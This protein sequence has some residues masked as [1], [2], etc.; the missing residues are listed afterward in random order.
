MIKQKFLTQNGIDRLS[1][2]C[3]FTGAKASVITEKTG[4]SRVGR[5]VKFKREADQL[6]TGF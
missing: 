3:P 2:G 1:H 6:G 5:M 4:N